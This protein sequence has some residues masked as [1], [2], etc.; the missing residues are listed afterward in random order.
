VSLARACAL[1]SLVA[2]GCS[3]AG[4]PIFDPE[5]VSL[6]NTEIDQSE[7]EAIGGTIRDVV[8]L[9]VPS[10]LHAPPGLV[11]AVKP[12]SSGGGTLT[13]DGTAA[14]PASDAQTFTLTLTYDAYMTSLIGAVAYPSW[15]FSSATPAT[16]TFAFA[17]EPTSPGAR[18]SIDGSFTGTLTASESKHDGDVDARLTISGFMLAD[19]VAGTTWNA[20]HVAGVIYSPASGYYANDAV[21]SRPFN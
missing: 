11:H 17:H 4:V 10:L 20:L 19:D 9:L 14:Q 3:S 8:A 12:S 21:F 6:R 13:V 5:H 1:A 2:A 16:L 18:G 15:R 7:L